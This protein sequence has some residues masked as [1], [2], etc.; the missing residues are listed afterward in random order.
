MYWEKQAQEN[1][2]S[3]R[4]KHNSANPMNISEPLQIF[5]LNL[6]DVMLI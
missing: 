1:D 6:H 4:E 3:Y 2:P 5:S